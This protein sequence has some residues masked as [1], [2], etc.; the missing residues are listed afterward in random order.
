[1]TQGG[2]GSGSRRRERNQQ[3]L[4]LNVSNDSSFEHENNNK[5]ADAVPCSQPKAHYKCKYF[6]LATK[7]FDFRIPF[8]SNW[9][10]V[11]RL[12]H[13]FCLCRK[14]HLALDTNVSINGSADEGDGLM[15]DLPAAT[16]WLPTLPGLDFFPRL[17][18]FVNL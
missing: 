5:S 15:S 17:Q 10:N 11:V 8:V 18:F 14:G 9:R 3:S 7:K 12:A 1:M 2:Q 4:A 16:F 13:A 6:S